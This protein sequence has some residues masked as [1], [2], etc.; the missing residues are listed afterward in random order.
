MIAAGPLYLV[1]FNDLR[2]VNPPN[3]RCKV[4]IP[5]SSNRVLV[6]PLEDLLHGRLQVIWMMDFEVYLVTLGP[7]QKIVPDLMTSKGI[8]I[9]N[10]NK[11]KFGTSEGHVDSSL[12]CQ[13]T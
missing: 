2:S 5:P 12:I 7:L 6:M 4:A 10:N 13:K 11:N 8:A 1:L 9:T 3:I